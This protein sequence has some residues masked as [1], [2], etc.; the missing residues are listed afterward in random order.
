MLFLYLPLL[1]T[2]TFIQ[3]F[4]CEFTEI[5]QQKELFFEIRKRLNSD[6]AINL[7]LGCNASKESKTLKVKGKQRFLDDRFYSGWL[8]LLNPNISVHLYLCGNYHGYEISSLIKALRNY[9]RHPNNLQ[10]DQYIINRYA[11]EQNLSFEESEK[12]LTSLADFYYKQIQ[13][14]FS[15]NLLAHWINLFPNL[16]LFVYSVAYEYKE[17]IQT[18]SKGR[19]FVQKYFLDK[20]SK[21]PVQSIPEFLKNLSMFSKAATDKKKGE[22]KLI[23]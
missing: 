4:F 6:F 14:D 21:S 13:K 23:F 22:Q 9:T 12:K 2:Q 10:V 3:D 7:V 5:F 1:W 17:K 15:G 8:A 11:C 19:E 16:P 20:H 18:S